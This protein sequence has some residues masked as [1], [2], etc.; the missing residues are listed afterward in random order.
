[1]E[2]FAKEAEFGDNIMVSTKAVGERLFCCTF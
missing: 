1:M 2:Q